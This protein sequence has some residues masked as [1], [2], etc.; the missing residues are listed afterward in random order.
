VSS[1]LIYHPRRVCKTFPGLRVYYDKPQGNQD[2]YV[3]NDPFLHTFCHM[4]ELS[5]PKPGDINFWVS[6]DVFPDFQHLFCD[7]VF[8][9]AKAGKVVWPK[10]NVISKSDP[11]VDTKFAFDDHYRWAWQHPFKSR[12]RVTLKADST[13]S[14]QPQD[15]SGTLLD[16]VPILG[17]LDVSLD[18][19]RASL[20]KG[21]ASKPMP[22]DGSIAADLWKYLVEYARVK[23]TGKQLQQVRQSHP[24]LASPWKLHKPEPGSGCTTGRKPSSIAPT[25]TCA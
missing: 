24:E 10:A 25:V 20:R 21:F 17:R 5:E 13:K 3:W 22:L 16:I 4:T 6:G 19:L 2:P 9:V 23:L 18:H 8:V 11:I 1:H 7:L 12:H 15:E 14:F